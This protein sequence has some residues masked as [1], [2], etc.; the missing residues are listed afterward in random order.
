MHEI[1]FYIYTLVPVHTTAHHLLLK[2]KQS[3]PRSFQET[4]LPEILPARMLLVLQYYP[5][6]QVPKPKPIY[7]VY[8]GT[9]NW[10]S[11]P[12]FGTERR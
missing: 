1:F 4:P 10:R 12:I 7:F 3:C 8:P 2:V 6:V 9:V 5:V 11:N